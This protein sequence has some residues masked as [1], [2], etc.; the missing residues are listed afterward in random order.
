MAPT[1]EQVAQSGAV[2]TTNGGSFTSMDWVLFDIQLIDGDLELAA[3]E[4]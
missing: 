2:A 4:K 3:C 1:D